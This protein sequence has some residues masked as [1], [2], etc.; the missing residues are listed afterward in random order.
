MRGSIFGVRL[1]AVAAVATC[2][3]T[4]GLLPT[5]FAEARVNFTPGSVGIGDPYVPHEGNGGYQVRS[6][7]LDMRF[8]PDTD[9]LQ[10]VATIQATATQN[11]SG[12][13]F[14]LYGLTVASVTVDGVAASFDRAPRELS[15]DFS[16][17]ITA[18]NR[19]T[20]VVDYHGK[21]EKLN[22]PDLGLSGW[23][24]TSDGAI[25]VGEPEAGMFWFP[26]NEHPSDKAKFNVDITVP[27]GLKAVSNGLQTAPPTSAGGWT[28]FSWASA[29]PMASYLATVAVG[30]WRVHQS[31]TRSGVP[32]TNYVDRSMSRS[33]DRSLNRGAEII[34]FLERKFGPYPFE[35][36]GGIADN[37]S[38]WYALENQT[39]PT[40]DERTVG[41][42]GLTGTVAHELAHQW[43][44]DSVALDR[45]RDIWL[46]EGFATYAEWMWRAHDG[47]PSV[48]AQ[49]DSA[50]ARPASSSFWS[51]KVTDPGYAHL[52]DGPIYSRGAMA[53]HAL[54]LKIGTKKF[55]RVMRTWASRRANGNGTTPEFKQLCERVASHPLDHLFDTW[56]VKGRKP[57]DPR[58]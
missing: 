11:L 19:F 8:N 31:M 25:L 22:D 28:T 53:L 30:N 6:Y 58:N 34:D 24:N 36:A 35:A 56:L 45:W 20:A 44:G 52:F 41:W 15:V 13:N 2:A 42:G 57:A 51:L 38:S 32:V 18:G 39:R 10:S 54:K 9:R 48:A 49:F 50:F 26:V 21:P 33:V 23:F 17:G 1:A 43:F 12:L 5:S 46:N 27:D 14:D 47:G 55:L 16:S 7:A 29:D 40:Y 4:V 3:L 37:F